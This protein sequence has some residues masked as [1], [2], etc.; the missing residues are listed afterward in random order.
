MRVISRSQILTL[1]KKAAESRYSVLE[2]LVCNADV[3]VRGEQIKSCGGEGEGLKNGDASNGNAC[4][5]GYINTV[6]IICLEPL[7]PI[8]V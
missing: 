5:V 7:Q 1:F 6:F 2:I 3:P 8:S 4:N